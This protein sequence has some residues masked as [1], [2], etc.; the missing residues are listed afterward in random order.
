M[1]ST[2]TECPTC[3]RTDFESERGVKLHHAQAHDESLA[4]TEK[5]CPVCGDSFTVDRSNADRRRC[6]SVECMGEW[7]SE[8]YSGEDHPRWEE[9]HTLTCVVCGDGFT[10]PPS[11]TDDRATCSKECMAKR[12]EEIFAEHGNPNHNGGGH[13]T[14]RN[15]GGSFYAT[16]H[17]QNHG[18]VYC[19]REC[20]GEDYTQRLTGE[21]GPSYKDSVTLG[22]EQCGDKFDVKPCDADTARFCSRD[23]LADW[24]SENRNGQDSHR[25]KGGHRVSDALRRIMGK[26][27]WN[28]TKKE[29]K[30]SE[31]KQCGATENLH[32]H[33]IVPLLAG[34]TNGAWNLMTLCGSCHATAEAYTTEYVEYV[35]SD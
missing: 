32:L 12:Q 9:Y 31:C 4:R 26:Q 33:H 21:N 5:T 30:G 1:S 35:C 29:H 13:V 18:A 27:S 20:M 17:Q 34:G 2:D 16:P 6:C 23:C 10:V 11:H 3:G 25:W 22:C 8:Q 7:R 19:S 24:Q 28:T 15:C 14:C